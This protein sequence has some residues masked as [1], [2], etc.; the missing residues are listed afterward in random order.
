MQKHIITTISPLLFALFINLI[1]LILFFVFDGQK[2]PQILE[3]GGLIESLSSAG[4]FLCLLL[5]SIL[6]GWAYIKKH[7]YFLLL[8][9]M[10]GLRELDFHNQFTTM[11][12]LKARFYLS[13][14]VPWFEKFI[15]AIVIALIIYVVIVIV[16]KYSRDF[17]SKLKQL[18]PTHIGAV[19]TFLFLGFTKSIDGIGRKLADINFIITPKSVGIFEVIEEILEMGIPMLIA[20]T[21][22]IYFKTLRGQQ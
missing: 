7:H 15:G 3:E 22:I 20:A 13:N 12:I 16:N 9:L 10:F 21:L 14:D 19:L 4:Y 1:V 8:I 11:S 2:H 18:S 17:F 5:A 6:G